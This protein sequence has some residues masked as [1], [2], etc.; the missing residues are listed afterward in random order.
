MTA[1]LARQF[2]DG[3]GMSPAL[4]VRAPGRVNLIGEHTDYNDGFVLPAAISVESRVVAAPRGDGV[5]RVMACD[6]GGATAQW[7]LDATY[8]A[9]PAHGW[10]DYIRAMTAAMSARGH[11]LTGADLAVSGTVPQGAGLSS[12][13]SLMVGIGTALAALSG[14]AIAPADIALMAQAGECD[15]VGVRCG[16]MDQLASACGVRDHALM[17]DCRSRAV[18]PVALPKGVEILI[19]H[20]GVAR[21][22]V[23]GAYN[24]RRAQCEAAAAAVGVSALRDADM[25]MLEG[26]RLDAVTLARARHVVTENA[27]VLA[28]AEALAAGDLVAMGALMAASHA[29]MRDDFRITVPAIDALVTELQ[30][31]IGLEGGARMTGGGFGGAVVAL[32]PADSAD[33]VLA[34]LTY[35]KPDGS[36]PLVLRETAC[37]GAGLVMS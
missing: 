18:R 27:R 34:G 22:L 19:V 21:G 17:I 7:P 15:H 33:A 12:S 29:S 30:A 3:F 32:C 16:I 37:D 31:L 28:A 6:F 24:D 14:L 1:P 23:E 5:I 25:A 20:S 35:R 8:A 13:A 36:P 10:A 2:A 11:A 26:A 4:V 9:D